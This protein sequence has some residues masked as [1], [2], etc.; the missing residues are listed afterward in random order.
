MDF[1]TYKKIKF[2]SQLTF[3]EIFEIF[4]WYCIQINRPPF[5]PEYLYMIIQHDT[6][7]QV[8]TGISINDAIQQIV[9]LYEEKNEGIHYLFNKDNQLI[10]IWIPKK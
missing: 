10:D 7:M 3:E 6:L 1:N 5:P 9:R 2:N 4:N 8:H